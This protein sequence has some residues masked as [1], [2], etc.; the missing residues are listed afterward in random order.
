MRRAP[1]VSFFR[2]QQQFRMEIQFDGD[3][4]LSEF[5]SAAE[6]H[7]AAME[8]AVDSLANDIQDEAAIAALFRAAHT[9]KGDSGV[10]GFGF[11][12]DALH[13]F[14]TELDYMR[15]GQYNLSDAL[16]DPLRNIV[17][18]VS[19]LLEAT[20]SGEKIELDFEDSVNELVEHR[21]DGASREVLKAP[22]AG[23]A[24][25]DDEDEFSELDSIEVD[26]PADSTAE[27]DDLNEVGTPATQDAVVSNEI[28]ATE[29][30]STE[31]QTTNPAQT[32]GDQTKFDSAQKHAKT[33]GK[34]ATRE[35]IK[36]DRDRLDK[37]IN[38]IG[39]LIIDQ[40]MVEQDVAQWQAETGNES[41]AMRRLTKTARDL[42]ELSLSL[43]MVPIAGVFQKMARTVRDLAR[44][45]GKEVSF[46]TEGDETEL[47]KTIVDK[48]GDP[49]LHMVRNAID[50]GIEMPGIREAS[51]KAAKGQITLRAFHQGGN[52]FIEIEDDGKGLDR[53][54]LLKKAIER[55]L[56]ADGDSLSD[57]E[58]LNLV[59]ASGFSTAA[60]VTDVSGRGVGMDV[61]RRNVEALQG[62]VSISSERGHGSTVTIRLPLTLAILDGLAVRVDDTVYI[63]PILSVIESFQPQPSDIQR[64]ANL[65]E[66]V[67][68]RDEVVPLLRLS[69]L[70]GTPSETAETVSEPLVVI[71][72][73]REKKYALMVDELL[74]KSQVVIKNLETNYQKVDGVAGA[75]ILGDGQIA[76]IIDIFGLVGLAKKKAPVSQSH[77]ANDQDADL[78][79]PMEIQGAI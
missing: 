33:S 78:N 55:G 13:C 71:V 10:V 47:D 3:E 63:V 52:I 28:S 61:V 69:E 74:G 49:L 39:E 12:S 37:L 25:F 11:I 75:T 17:D 66:M 24:F 1:R 58:I 76:M 43:R 62:S 21:V 60:A 20:R 19:F 29:V 36:V 26:T 38:V 22:E 9:L 67:T 35:S 6:D 14:E 56:I 31:S 57:Q 45:L 59:F 50:H 23:F 40:S 77:I 5:F 8:V 72:E 44:K 30:S 73:E 70:L 79:Q 64:I 48:I 2:K 7:L 65:S 53:G 34:L 41:I 27:S 18:Q 46:E 68:V 42:Q 15:S 51:G 32:P 54:A 4:L 16:I